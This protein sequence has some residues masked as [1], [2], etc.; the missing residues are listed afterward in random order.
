MAGPDRV[1]PPAKGEVH[2]WIQA[3]DT[4]DAV[5][6]PLAR[7]LSP[8]EHVRGRAFRFD[9]DRRL[10]VARRG[11]LRAVLA[12]YAG[13]PPER[14]SFAYGPHGKPALADD[15]GP[16]GLSFNLSH[17]QGLAALALTG[18]A[19]VGVDVE[20]LRPMSDADQIA[21]R[22]FSPAERRAL[23]AIPPSDRTAAFFSCWT[24]KEAYVKATG[25]GLS[26]PLDS[27]DVNV[28]PGQPAR[29][30]RVGEDAA[31]AGRWSLCHLEPAPGYVGAVA[32]PGPAVSLLRRA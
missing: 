23:R 6:D 2:V 27:F 18:A 10:F 30:E 29:L 32:V 17:S 14:V 4:S 9:K 31:V 13:V 26:C 28:Q 15:L 8:D 25:D 22:F 21:E 19:A 16:A 11:W 7:T 20:A 5:L 3:L 24:R 12:R 1:A